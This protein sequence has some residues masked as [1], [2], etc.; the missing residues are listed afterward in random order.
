MRPQLTVILPCAGEGTRFG[1]T[2]RKE[3]HCIGPGEALV[4]RAVFPFLAPKVLE[5]YAIR[6][7]VVSRAARPDTLVYLASRY[8]RSVEIVGVFQ[9]EGSR[10][11]RDA[12]ATGAAVATGSTVLALPDHVPH[13]ASP[14][15]VL[16]LLDLAEDG[17]ALLV[18]PM[19]PTALRSETALRTAAEDGNG[20]RVV[21]AADRPDDPTSFDAGWFALAVPPEERDRLVEATSVSGLQRLVGASVVSID[22]FDNINHLVDLEAGHV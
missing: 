12:V 16:H 5:R 3:L 10:E 14:A 22:A 15:R 9:P 11:L 21:A 1:A 13:G 18:A 7:V 19:N 4:D 2:Y 6:L 17:L 20:L 8:G